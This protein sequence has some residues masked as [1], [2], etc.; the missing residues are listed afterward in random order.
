MKLDLRWNFHFYLSNLLVVAS[1]NQPTV[2]EHNV[3][4]QFVWEFFQFFLLFVHSDNNMCQEMM[5][6]M[7]STL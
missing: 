6:I 7:W 2:L 3:V 5:K 4:I 1:F